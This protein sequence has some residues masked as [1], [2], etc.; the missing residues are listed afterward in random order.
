MAGRDMHVHRP[1]GTRLAHDDDRLLIDQHRTAVAD[2]D[3]AVDAGSNRAA[4]TDAD[5]D[6]A[7][8]GATHGQQGGNGDKNTAHMNP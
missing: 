2:V 6:V 4:D 7:G 8:V 3:P 5:I 1:D